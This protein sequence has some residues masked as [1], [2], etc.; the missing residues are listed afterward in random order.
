MNK[1][2]FISPL[3]GYCAEPKPSTFFIPDAFKKLP[4]Y[5]KDQNDSTVKRCMPFLDSL[6]SG[7]I[8]PFPCD[9]EIWVDEEADQVK[10]TCND[11][12]GDMFSNIIGISSHPNFQTAEEMRNPKRTVD[13][14]FKF[15]NPWKVVTPKG[16]SCLFV[17][18][19]N[20]ALPFD[21]ITGIVDTDEFIMNVN[22]PFYWTEDLKKRTL[23]KQGSPMAMVI[24]FKREDWK[25]STE[26]V[27]EDELITNKQKFA[28][29]SRLFNNYKSLFWKKKSFK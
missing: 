4:P 22:F 2:K 29:F 1:I 28:Y 3:K 13:V 6:T 18:P 23:L 27:E 20:H 9:F 8:I 12:L 16:Y 5:I 19:F 7:Y 21:L 11:Q 15:L 17:T 10:F 25:M 24:P 14:A 26:Y